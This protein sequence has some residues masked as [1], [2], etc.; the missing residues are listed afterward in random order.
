MQ[1]TTSAK[2]LRV[3]WGLKA[4]E[5]IR[6]LRYRSD[7]DRIVVNTSELDEPSLT[8]LM[9]WA[10]KEHRSVYN[11]IT[12]W[13]LLRKKPE[14]APVRN[15]QELQAALK[16]AIAATERKWLFARNGDGLLVPWFV[17]EVEYSPAKKQRG[18]EQP[19]MTT[20]SMIAVD[21]GEQVHNQIRWYR[22][23]FLKKDMRLSAF[24]E[25]SD[26]YLETEEA[27][28][29]YEKQIKG[30]ANVCNT[31]GQMYRATGMGF[32]Q[33]GT[34]WWKST[35]V[36]SLVRDNVSSRV[37]M[38]EEGDYDDEDDANHERQ[39]ASTTCVTDYWDAPG[40]VPKSSDSDV[41]DDEGAGW[42]VPVLPYVQ[43]FSLETHDFVT[44][45]TSGLTPYEYANDLEKKLIL[46]TEV[47]ELVNI[48]ISGAADRMEDIV[49]GK[50]GGVIVL[51]TGVPGTG[52][53]LTAEVMS[54][55]IKRPLYTVQCAQLGTNE[56]ELEKKLKQV[57][58]RCKRW[59]AVLL[60]DE[61]D[62]YVRARGTDIKQNAIVGVFLRLLERFQGVLF[63]TS[64][65]QELDDAIVSR[66][67]AHIRYTVPDQESLELIWEVLSGNYGLNLM[68]AEFKVLAQEF[69][70]ITG[71]NVK[72]LCKLATAI[73]VKQKY[74]R[75]EALDMIRKV[76]KFVDFPP[77]AKRQASSPEKQT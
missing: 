28:E 18:Y 75:A 48:L 38:D 12:H 46:P 17:T 8:T 26:V 65:I 69:P 57:L 49:S 1:F 51:A 30:Y 24:L 40:S 68:P 3:C 45:H 15:L 42:R 50:S 47:K 73:S 33:R 19:A 52:K 60:I 25:A 32:A 34:H 71:R 61:A 62:V 76:S 21:R 20:I 39:A 5:I 31:L 43:V 67:I 2:N 6:E 22:E 55:Q 66:A 36:V 77:H 29:D 7:N 16:S 11:R 53:T 56:E 58:D 59:G 27:L 41:Q 13:L 10:E 14:G 74:T 9:A 64:N 63:L 70:G 4:P 44:L 72:T 23:S 54:E 37:I 35:T